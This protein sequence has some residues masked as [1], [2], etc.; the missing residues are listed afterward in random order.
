MTVKAITAWMVLNATDIPNAFDAA[1]N[2]NETALLAGY[3]AAFR[4]VDLTQDVSPAHTAALQAVLVIDRVQRMAAFMAVP[5]NVSHARAA[6]R[7]GR[8]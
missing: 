5:G 3:V 8:V 6:A 2:P 7:G 1:G 4:D